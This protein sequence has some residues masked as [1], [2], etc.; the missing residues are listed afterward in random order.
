MTQRKP[1]ATLDTNVWAAGISLEYSI[2]ARIINAC[3]WR[4]FKVFLLLGLDT[5]IT[6]SQELGDEQY[7]QNETMCGS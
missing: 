3:E 7:E 6:L 1:R 4:L 5:F 2:C